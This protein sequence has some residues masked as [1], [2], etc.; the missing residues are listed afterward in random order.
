MKNRIRIV[1][2]PQSR[3]D[4]RALRAFIARDAP[5]TA[6]AFVRRL[7]LSVNRLR[8]F[9]RGGQ[10][11]PETNDTDIREIIF[12]TYRIIYH[13]SGN[14][15]EILTVYHAARLLDETDL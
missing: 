11:V 14:Q 2:T 5:K 12:G 3:E 15:I 8:T 4:V 9:P 7:R 10:V 1:W 6:A 13:V